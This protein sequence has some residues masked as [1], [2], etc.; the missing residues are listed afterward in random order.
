MASFCSSTRKT[1]CP[2]NGQ[3]SHLDPSVCDAC[4]SKGQNATRVD[5]LLVYRP[6][7]NYE[8][9]RPFYLCGECLEIYNNLDI[10]RILVYENDPIYALGNT[11]VYEKKVHSLGKTFM[12]AEERN[13]S[14][15]K[16]Q[17][18]VYE[19]GDLAAVRNSIPVWYDWYGLI[20]RGHFAT[21]AEAEHHIKALELINS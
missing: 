12:T 5:V 17:I 3:Y 13:G 16:F 19:N 8:E 4:D 1:G 9:T 10:K 6:R 20:I 11:L 18:V 21:R 7:Q 15:S 14:Q 2:C